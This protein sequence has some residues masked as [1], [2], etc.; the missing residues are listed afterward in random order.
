MPR[1]A[2]PKNPRWRAES[3]SHSKCHK[4]S[5]AA[6]SGPPRFLQFLQGEV[7]A[8]LWVFFP[9][10]V[11]LRVKI[12]FMPLARGQHEA[13]VDDLPAGRI[14]NHDPLITTTGSER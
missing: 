1:M 11:G 3:K 6:G 2:A 10:A 14:E 4:G 13:A 9:A 12:G 8:F 7:F 5:A